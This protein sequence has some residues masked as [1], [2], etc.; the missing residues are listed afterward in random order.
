VRCVRSSRAYRCGSKV[1]PEMYRTSCPLGRLLHRQA[2]PGS[3]SEA[4]AMRL[5]VVVESNA[6][7]LAHER[8]N[9][10]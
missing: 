6:W 5:P 7:T 9:A 8:Y 4:L 1:S 2:G 3:I 10:E